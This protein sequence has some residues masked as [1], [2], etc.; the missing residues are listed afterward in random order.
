[1]LQVFLNAVLP[2]FA[3]VAVG[4]AYGRKGV[5]STELAMQLNRFVFYFALPVLLFRRLAGVSIEQ[6]KWGYVFTYLLAELTLY[7]IGYALARYVFKLGR[8]ES[9]LMGMAAGFVNHVMF[10]LPIAEQLLG[11]QSLVAI[12]GIITLDSVILFAGMIMVL[13]TLAGKGETKSL[14]KMI[15]VFATNPQLIGIGLGVLAMV[16]GFEISGG[17]DLFTQFVGNAAAPSS[18]FALGIILASQKFANFVPAAVFSILKLVIMPLVVWIFL[19]ILVKA[20][21]GWAMPALLVA[22]GPAGLMP[23][24][25]ALQYKVPV[26]NIAYIVLISTIGSVASI[27]LVAQWM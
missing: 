17:L 4:F 13:E 11:A 21:P 2:I 14:L 8:L 20:D 9:L 25:L 16:A 12:V 18:L 19:M 7:A 24:V 5:V 15:P 22:A 6:F 26:S 10:V 27:T 3:V 1:M 23:F